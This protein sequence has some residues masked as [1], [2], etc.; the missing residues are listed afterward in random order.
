[1]TTLQSLLCGEC[2]AKTRK[3]MESLQ[4]ALGRRDETS[5]YLLLDRLSHT[6]CMAC[7]PG[8]NKLRNQV[9]H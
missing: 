3:L 6:V 5:V 8:I 4:Y 9:T 1:M 2:L 7:W